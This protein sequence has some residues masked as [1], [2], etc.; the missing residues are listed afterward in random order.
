MHPPTEGL[1]HDKLI[2][3]DE[4][5]DPS[6]TLMIDSDT[7]SSH[8][9]PNKSYA[10]TYKHVE[11]ATTVGVMLGTD[12]DGDDVVGKDVDGDEV[13]GDV[14]GIKDGDDDNVSE[15]TA[16]TS[17]MAPPTHTPSTILKCSSS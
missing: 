4:A 17:P 6:S 12:V 5:D 13:A 16:D 7:S 3:V 1:K 15:H 2:F 14:D 11:R 8:P 9:S 10:L